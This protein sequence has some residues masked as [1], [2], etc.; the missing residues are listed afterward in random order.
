MKTLFVILFLPVLASGVT[1]ESWVASH[2][3]TGAD[4][5]E[6]ADPDK[7][8]MVNLMEYALDGGLPAAHGPLSIR[9]EFGWSM[10][11]ADGG[12][13]EM[14]SKPIAGAPIGSH[15]ALKY[16][17][18]TGIED[19]SAEALVSMPCPASQTD[20]S[21]VRWVGGQAM[22]RVLN[23]AGGKLQ[24][25]C[26]LRSDLVSRGFMKL[27]IT[28]GAGYTM[29][30]VEGTAQPTLQLDLGPT[31]VSMRTVGSP[32]NTTPTDRDITYT[33]VSSPLQV[34]DFSWPWALGGSGYSAG[35][36]TRSSSNLSV[37][38]PNVGNTSLWTYQSDGTAEIQIITPARTYSRL[39]NTFSSSSVVSRTQGTSVTG[40]LRRHCDTYVDGRISATTSYSDR[41]NL[42]SSRDSLSGTYVRNTNC[43]TADLDMTPL[44]A[45]NSDGGYQKGPTLVTP[46]HIIGAVHH[47]WNPGTT[48][49]FVTPSNVTHT[50]TITDTAVV[51]GTDILL[52]KL[53]SDVPAG[54]DFV[55]VLPSGWAAKL[56]TLS[57]FGMPVFSSDQGK[58]VYVRNVRSIS[59]FVQCEPPNL[60]SRIGFYKAAV[61]G[62]SGS[63]CF[64]AVGGEMVLL[65]CWYGGDGGSGPS[66]ENYASAINSALSTLGGGYSLTTVNLGSYTSF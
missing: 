18:R 43:V 28:R 53:D 41:Q 25:V 7:D 12:F 15:L 23:A 38:S 4:A 14:V 27:R 55:K 16:K 33:Q 46:R 19:V 3:L 44:A 61:Q 6:N 50:R 22:I 40:S 21:L 8:G 31:S 64:A 45:W 10:A 65:C 49:H 57:I 34:S 58:R 35:D 32:T 37:I 9:P 13:S 48:V 66:V 24:A 29:P 51:T 17:I 30:P 36:V 54:I 26:R 47:G 60:F 39:V 52:G 62:D 1:F 5:A 59:T 2:G 56:P 63:P 20:A 42:F 11:L